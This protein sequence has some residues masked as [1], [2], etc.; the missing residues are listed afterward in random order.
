MRNPVEEKV[1]LLL[2][3]TAEK[4]VKKLDAEQDAAGGPPLCGM[5]LHQPKRPQK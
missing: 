1:L 4:E 3:K 5:I 2:Q